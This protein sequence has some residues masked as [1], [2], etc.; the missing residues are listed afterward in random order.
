MLHLLAKA[1]VGSEGAAMNKKKHCKPGRQIQMQLIYTAHSDHYQMVWKNFK[2]AHFSSVLSVWTYSEL[3]WH[4]WIH[5]HE[6]YSK[7]Q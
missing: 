4:L 2:P 6:N 5:V 3:Q 7:N 1:E